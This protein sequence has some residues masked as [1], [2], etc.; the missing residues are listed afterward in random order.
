MATAA[1]H[2]SGL[3][4]RGV[5]HHRVG[6]TES[7]RQGSSDDAARRALRL[8]LRHL[9]QRAHLLLQHRPHAYARCGKDAE[10]ARL[11]SQGHA[12][13]S[14][15]IDAAVCAACHLI[16]GSQP[17]PRA[18]RA[19]QP[20]HRGGARQFQGFF[21]CLVKPTDSKFLKSIAATRVTIQHYFTTSQLTSISDACIFDDL[22]NRLGQC[23]SRSRSTSPTTSN[24]MPHLGYRSEPRWRLDECRA[25][26]RAA[27]AVCISSSHLAGTSFSAAASAAAVTA[28]NAPATVF[29]IAVRA[30]A[31]RKASAAAAA[32]GS[33]RWRGGRQY[34]S[35]R[36]HGLRQHELGRDLGAEGRA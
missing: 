9:R 15:V 32:E 1:A 16:A 4:D 18:G 35:S 10:V 17:T 12:A 13:G 2:H 30:E 8:E 29:P 27:A 34:S 20:S 3:F 7:K 22:R 36:S 14:C 24:A 19:R 5:R 33:A 31:Q 28:S 25:D 6:G 21:V 23:W 26:A 11:V